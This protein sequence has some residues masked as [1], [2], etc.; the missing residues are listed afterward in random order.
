[1]ASPSV[2]IVNANPLLN[3]V[4]PAAIAVG[5]IQRVPR[6]ETSAEG[7]GVNVARVLSALGHSVFVTG[8]AGGHSGAWLEE[9]LSLE[10]LETRMIRTAAPMRMGFMAAPAEAS[11]PTSI[12]PQGFEV[13]QAE[14]EAL[15]EA[16]AHLLD[17][18]PSLMIISGGLPDPTLSALYPRLL[19]LAWRQG[20]P[21]WLDA[22]GEG[23]KEALQAPHGPGLG[24]PNAE[25]L[26]E[27]MD[28]VRVPE[29]HITRG[30]APATVMIE[31]KSV[32]DVIPPPLVQINPIGC[33]D[34]YLAG[35]AHGHLN[36]WS[37][38]DRCR[39]ASA[40]GAANARRPDVAAIQMSDIMALIEG[41]TFA[42][43]TA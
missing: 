40:A 20:I 27:C 22:H 34:C 30:E 32:F 7:K 38:E 21:A 4:L 26:A 25:E 8:F 28:W 16:T 35:L 43:S 39:F 37:L 24:K 41:V 11:H 1:M 5:T 29:L 3:L 31:G 14:G 9:L 12:L 33:G 17:R 15:I 42:P 2:L 10:G 18:N 19:E 23:L 13:T 6:L 36:G